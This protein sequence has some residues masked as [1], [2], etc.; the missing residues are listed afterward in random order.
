MPR[1]S[2][3]PAGMNPTHTAAWHW[4]IKEHGYTPDTL[5]F[6]RRRAPS[7]LGH[8]GREDS[9]GWEPKLVR[10]AV[11]TFTES[12]I[13]QMA[14]HPKCSVLVWSIGGKAPEAIMPVRDTWIGEMPAYWRQYR[15]VVVGVG[16]V[17]G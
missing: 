2:A 11:I 9:R 5:T 10:N 4:L 13:E 6:Q 16:R 7:F 1:P 17:A 3:V 15:I 14:E 12:Q 8:D